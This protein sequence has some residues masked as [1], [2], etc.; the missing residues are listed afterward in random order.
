MKT[1]LIC[2]Q[3]GGVGKTLLA[4]EIA[5]SLERDEIKFNF[6]DLDQQGSSI[7]ETTQQ[8]DAVV[9]VIDTTG[10]LKTELKACMKDADF[11]LIPTTLS[12]GD[13]TPLLTTLE[14]YNSLN[15]K[16][17]LLVVFNLWDRF[18]ASKE[19]TS[20]FENNCPDIKTAILCR[21]TAFRDAA[22]RHKSIEQYDSKNP[23]AK[24][25]RDIYSIIKYELNLKEG[26]R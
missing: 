11:I 12:E 19:F 8:D 13:K 14:I 6:Y 10:A 16:A 22:S 25:I 17:P 15:K 23:G 18:N 20:W 5:F 7:H 26:F 4:D 3:K 21:A 1:I 9:Q 2:N 24:Q